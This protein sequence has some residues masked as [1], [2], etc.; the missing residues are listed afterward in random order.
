MRAALDRGEWEISALIH[1]PPLPA[2]TR[3]H[4]VLEQAPGALVIDTGPAAVLGV[5]CDPVVREHARNGVTLVNAGNG[6]TLCVSL[7]GE[8]VC[9]IFEHHTA[10][11]D[12]KHLLALIQRLQNGSLRERE[13]FDEGGH[14][15]AVNRPLPAT[16]IAVTGPNRKRLLPDAYHAAPYGDMMLSGCFGLLSAWKKLRG[17]LP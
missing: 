1:D 10:A 11:L 8:E 12:R 17:H 13:I 15:A 5:L 2:M 14:G 7:K 3:M 9:G 16:F 6:H 4:A